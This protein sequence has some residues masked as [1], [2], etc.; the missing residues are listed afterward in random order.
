MPG[1]G[2]AFGPDNAGDAEVEQSG[3]IAV[4]DEDVGRLDVAVDHPELVGVVQRIEHLAGP[5]DD[6]RG[7][8]DGAPFETALQRFAPHELGHHVQHALVLREAVQAKDVR[9][10]QA[11]QDLGLAA[12]SLG[13][14]ALDVGVL[15][16]DLDRDLTTEHLVGREVHGTHSPLAEEGIDAVLPQSCPDHSRSPE[17]RRSAP[18]ALPSSA[19]AERNVGSRRAV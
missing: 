17:A 18:A 16:Q 1:L 6:L 5:F 2:R 13:G 8:D 15:A 14:G 11:G 3:A 12:E 9:V 10:I 19:E 7:A 4:V